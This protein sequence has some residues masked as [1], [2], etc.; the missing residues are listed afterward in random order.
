MQVG[1]EFIRI[2]PSQPRR[3]WF[4]VGTRWFAILASIGFAAVLVTNILI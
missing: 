4:E 3:D 1:N 2:I